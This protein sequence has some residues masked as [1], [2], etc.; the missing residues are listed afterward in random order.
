MENLI[1]YIGEFLLCILLALFIYKHSRNNITQIS[2]LTLEHDKRKV[3][4]DKIRFMNLKV[5]WNNPYRRFG[6]SYLIRLKDNLY[7]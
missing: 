2:S 3:L 7:E 5:W 1:L 4:F 6:S